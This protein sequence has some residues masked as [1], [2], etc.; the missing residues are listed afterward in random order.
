M[1]RVLVA[2]AH[3]GTKNR[4]YLLRLLH[5]FRAM[6]RFKVEIALLVDR[7][8][9]LGSDLNYLVGAPTANPWSLPFLHRPYFS[10]RLDDYDLFIY[11]EDD[12]LLEEHHITAFL[13]VND[14]LPE[15]AVPGFLR[16]EV[17]SRGRRS[18]NDIAYGFHWDPTSAVTIEGELYAQHTN[19]HSA[20]YMLT[21]A[22]LQR[23]IATG[24]YLAPPSPGRFDLLVHA[25]TSPYT[26]G[27]LRKLIPLDRIAD[28]TLHHLPNRY[29]GRTGIDQRDLDDQIAALRQIGAGEQSARELLTP[30][31]ERPT[32]RWDKSYHERLPLRPQHVIHD[33]STRM[34]SVGT[35]NGALERSFVAAGVRVTGIPL[36]EVVAANARRRGVDTTAPDVD[37]ALASFQRRRF[38]QVLAVNILQFVEDPVDL[39]ARL[40][41]LLAPSGTMLVTVPNLPR[42]VLQRQL[43]RRLGWIPERGRRD[44]GI[45]WTSAAV[46]DGWS[47]A[48]GLTCLA[49]STPTKAGYRSPPLGTHRWLST[50]VVARLGT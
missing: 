45:H 41:E 24:D 46:V 19:P 36:D 9:S 7:P 18:Y 42:A 49:L 15:D 25:A 14:R 5:R 23:V 34:L 8:V 32:V 35:G 16:F 4:H 3:H 12:T 40:G 38:D 21:R 50:D 22:Q 37:A 29:L 26:C 28:F 31:R 33:Q 43:T 27:A 44:R 11:T 30:H 48:A 17:D 6:T 13:E 1:M 39:L 47:R 10:E 2:I 20:M